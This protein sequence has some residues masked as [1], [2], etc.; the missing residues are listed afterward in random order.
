[1]WK[2]KFTKF[3]I[4]ISFLIFVD[5]KHSPPPEPEE[6]Q[7]VK[8]AYHSGHLTV[9]QSILSDRKKERDL[10]KEEQKLYLKSLFYLS[11]WKEFF[12]EWNQFE[13]KT[14][15]IVLYY[16]KAVVISREKPTIGIEEEN[17]L[18]ELLPVSPEA[19]LLY[20][21]WKGKKINPTQKKLFLAQSK[22]FDTFL[23]RIEKEIGD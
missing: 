11:E 7:I 1:M 23:S 13:T 19:C 10:T 16:F 5:C 21:Q 9:V 4:L 12:K 3:L 20:L 2:L 17:L 18:L 6:Y 8:N 15:D 22:Q 14:P